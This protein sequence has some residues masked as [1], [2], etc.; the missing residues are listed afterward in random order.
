MALKRIHPKRTNMRFLYEANAEWDIYAESRLVDLVLG[1]YIHGCPMMAFP[2][3]FEQEET[4]QVG[5]WVE[6]IEGIPD[7]LQP[8]WEAYLNGNLPPTFGD[9][10]RVCDS[11]AADGSFHVEFARKLGYNC[12]RQG[13]G[14]RFGPGEATYVK[15]AQSRLRKI[16]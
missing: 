6:V 15:D 9:R 16:E 8:S 5:D 13:H 11:Y 14:W 2:A 7:A 10:G 3:T 12:S 4:F 1:G